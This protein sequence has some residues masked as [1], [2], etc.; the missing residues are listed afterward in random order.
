MI[1]FWE[2]ESSFALIP[3]E[4]PFCFFADSQHSEE[5]KQ[6]LKEHEEKKDRVIEKYKHK[7][8]ERKVK[9]KRLC[10][11][12]LYLFY[13]SS[14]ARGQDRVSR[15]AK[16]ILAQARIQTGFHRF[17]NLVPRVHVLQEQRSFPAPPDKGNAGSE[18]RLPFHGNQSSSCPSD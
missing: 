15:A 1:L 7:C 3:A 16:L 4:S 2:N 5:W 13:S 9:K 11:L 8:E 10:L 12:Y 18:T 6:T 17:T 14:G